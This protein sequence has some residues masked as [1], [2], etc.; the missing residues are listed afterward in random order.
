MEKIT[1]IATVPGLA[2]ID[3]NM[4][5]AEFRLLALIQTKSGPKGCT[6]SNATLGGVLGFTPATIRKRVESLIQM[7]WL[8]EVEAGKKRTLK[9]SLE[10]MEMQEVKP[11][12]VD[13]DLFDPKNI[14]VDEKD[15]NHLIALFLKY[16]INPNVCR[17]G[18]LMNMFYANPFN[19]DGCKKLI[20]EHGVSKV[21]EILRKYAD[22]MDEK[23]CPRLKS[24]HELYKR[25]TQVN[26]YLNR[27][28]ER[29]ITIV[30]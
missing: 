19:R 22:R 27:K 14:K 23:F 4:S 8:Y 5:D 9:V 15:I 3:S 24:L 12:P 16:R 6:D 10:K 7:G 17:N 21:E 2:L 26:E 1:S 29:R 28:E 13:R 11:P 20:R 18:D 30:D 25:W